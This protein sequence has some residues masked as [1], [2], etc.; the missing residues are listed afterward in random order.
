MGEQFTRADWRPGAKG[1]RRPR[2]RDYGGQK[3]APAAF[4]E[5]AK[6]FQI[7][8]AG[9]PR[10]CRYCKRLALRGVA[11]CAFHG[12]AWKLAEL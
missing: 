2:K 6:A 4:L 12:G 5:A 7:G 11:V 8:S 9:A 1:K 10:A 3:R